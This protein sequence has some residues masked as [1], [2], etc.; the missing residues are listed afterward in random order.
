MA[1]SDGGMHGLRIQS[2][3]ETEVGTSK[4]AGVLAGGIALS[5]LGWGASRGWA[6]SPEPSLPRPTPGAERRSDALPGA[7]QP[8]RDERA[9]I[10]PPPATPPPIIASEVRPIDLATA[11]RLANVEN[12]ELNA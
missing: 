6:Q 2:G 8:R 9:Q 10:V 12:P 3:Q 4:T 11:L 7:A 5:I 1:R